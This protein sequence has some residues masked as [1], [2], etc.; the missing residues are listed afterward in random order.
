A[1]SNAAGNSL[2]RRARRL[3]GIAARL[4]LSTGSERV[5]GHLSHSGQHMVPVA[6]ELLA[7]A[8]PSKAFS[9]ALEALRH[10]SVLHGR[11]CKLLSEYGSDTFMLSDALA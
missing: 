3:I 1:I 11:R 5:T 7:K 9:N 4:G 6:N 10:A 2:N 8:S